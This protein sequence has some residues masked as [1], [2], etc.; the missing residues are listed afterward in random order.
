MPRYG[1]SGVSGCRASSQLPSHGRNANEDDP[2]RPWQPSRAE[3]GKYL[4]TVKRELRPEHLACS[5]DSSPIGLR[6][7]EDEEHPL[8]TAVSGLQCDASSKCLC[9]RQAGLVLDCDGVSTIRDGLVPRP[10]VA[11]VTD[12]HFRPHSEAWAESN[13]EGADQAEMASIAEGI[14]TRKRPNRQVQANHRAESRRDQDVQPRSEPALNAAQLGW[15]NAGCTGHGC[16]GQA[17]CLSG[18]PDLIAEVGKQAPAAAGPTGRVR[19]GHRHILTERPH[20]PINRT[21]TIGP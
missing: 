11:C 17:G 1:R 19:L 18:S 6:I 5:E 10:L 7:R 21:A 9:V 13:A 12:G 4:C 8:D 14:S 15:R 2:T 16:Q 20:Q 3:R